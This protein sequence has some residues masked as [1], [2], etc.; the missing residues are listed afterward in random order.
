MEDKLKALTA[1]R[2]KKKTT[3]D[4]ETQAHYQHLWRVLLTVS[5]FFFGRIGFVYKLWDSVFSRVE[6]AICKSDSRQ[7]HPFG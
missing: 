7:P 3:W 5:L 2:V 6:Q 1:Y 4:P